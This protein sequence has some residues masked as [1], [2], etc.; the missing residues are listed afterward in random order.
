MSKS[1]STLVSEISPQAAWKILSSDSRALMV[2][3][4]TRPEWGFV[5]GP[6]LSE[7]EQTV[8]QIE[9]LAY[10]DMSPN[11]AF[12]RT[13]MDSIGGNVP[14]HL[15]FI[16]RSGARSLNAA[17]AVADALS[18]E[19]LDVPC[20]NVVNG[21]EGDCDAQGRRGAL[22]GWKASGLPWRQT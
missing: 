9:W 15:L 22:N 2:D 21:F 6:D 19:G 16:C 1:G 20:I 11:P 4:R 5:G 17:Y 10:P 7:V 13:L 14:S 8:M 18:A 3:V 12:V